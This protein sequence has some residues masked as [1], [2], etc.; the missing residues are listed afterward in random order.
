MGRSASATRDVVTMRMAAE[1]DDWHDVSL[2]TEVDLKKSSPFTMIVWCSAK[3]G[4]SRVNIHVGRVTNNG[5]SI[6]WLWHCPSNA[7]SVRGIEGSNG[8]R[9]L[10]TLRIVKPDGGNT[11][12]LEG[13]SGAALEGQRRTVGRQEQN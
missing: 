13:G 1:M 4:P 2:H 11:G 12:S 3:A 7:E 8:P 10:S 5:R 9:C 6:P